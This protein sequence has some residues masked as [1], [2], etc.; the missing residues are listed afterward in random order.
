MP[1]AWNKCGTM[2]ERPALEMTASEARREVLKLRMR[3]V[4]LQREIERGRRLT[5]TEQVAN[6]ERGLELAPGQLSD[7]ISH[8]TPSN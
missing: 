3:V 7:A 4:I 6:L 1:A 2:S 8:R 5:S